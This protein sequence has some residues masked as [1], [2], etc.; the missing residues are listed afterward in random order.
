MKNLNQDIYI[1]GDTHG[2]WEALFRKIDHLGIGNCYLIHVGDGGEGFLTK[3]KQLRQFEHLN[4]CF[5]KRNIQ[6]KSIRGNHS[7]PD[8]FQGQ[9]KH[10]HFE[11]IPDYTYREFNGE[12]FLFVGGAIS[13]DRRLRVPHMSWWE[14]EAFVLKPELVEKVDVLITH[15]IPQWSGDFQKS[16]IVSW[17]EKDSTL[18][19]EAVIERENISKLIELCQPKKH[20]SGHFHKSC[21]TSYNGCDSLILDI[22]EI[23]EHR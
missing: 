19:E 20:Y 23:V 21:F 2:E 14:D 9:V 18:W 6:Y 12:K 8:Y 11:L 22:L 10:S 17:C 1:V 7:D 16:G 15:T 4:N 13:I 3:E 5:K